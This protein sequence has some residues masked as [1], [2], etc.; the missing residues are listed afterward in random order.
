VTAT[1]V[2]TDKVDETS[3]VVIVNGFVPKT[4]AAPDGSPI[5]L[6]VSVQALLLPVFEIV[7]FP[8]TAVAPGATETLVGDAT[9]TEPG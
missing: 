4:A 8:K 7:T 2:V 5:A 1:V 9:V 6:S 3:V